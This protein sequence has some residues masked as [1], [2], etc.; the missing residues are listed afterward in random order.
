MQG[1]DRED[2]SSM[3]KLVVAALQLS[4]T[5]IQMANEELEQLK[6]KLKKLE[7]FKINLANDQELGKE[8]R[9]FFEEKLINTEY[10]Q[11]VVKKKK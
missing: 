3:S 9:K 2:K 7:S 4:A 11:N 5:T 6:E 10:V 8:V 1:V